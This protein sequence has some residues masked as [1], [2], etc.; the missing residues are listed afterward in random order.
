MEIEIGRGKNGE[1]E[2][3]RNRDEERWRV[4]SFGTPGHERL[5]QGQRIYFVIVNIQKIV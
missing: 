5:G 2:R 3:G 4:G 1:R